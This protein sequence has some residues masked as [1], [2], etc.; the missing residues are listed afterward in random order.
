MEAQRQ[1]L[2]RSRARAVRAAVKPA[3]AALFAAEPRLLSDYLAPMGAA[4]WSALANEM[5]D[6]PV[7]NF[8]AWFYNHRLTHFRARFCQDARDLAKQFPRGLHCGKWR[9]KPASTLAGRA[10]GSLPDW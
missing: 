3:V 8:A 10:L 6:F 7:E 4:I 1:Q 9:E 5:L 2:A